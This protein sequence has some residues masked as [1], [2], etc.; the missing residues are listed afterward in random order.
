MTPLALLALISAL[1]V[2][3]LWAWRERARHNARLLAAEADA[4]RL[5]RLERA[6]AEAANLLLALST[7]IDLAR[8][9]PEDER[10]RWLA[11]A[12][13]ASQALVGLF[14][15]ARA[16]VAGAEAPERWPLEG[17]LRLAVALA[18]AEGAGI[19]LLGR[20]GGHRLA[21]DV[22]AA[23]DALQRALLALH[24]RRDGGAYVA[25]TLEAE[26]VTLSV[27]GE[28]ALD[29]RALGEALAPAGWRASA[30]R[31]G[32]VFQVSLRPVH[33]DREDRDPEAL[34][35]AAPGLA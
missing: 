5:R 34:P 24:A 30:A 20:G 23:V 2:A 29:L 16:L 14:E 13:E 22:E 6:G 3:L 18:R 17:A 4:R 35:R 19:E 7:S 1:V 15:A 33:P 8:T 28:P 10:E 9:S 31:R 11:N 12:E 21:G 25:A 27:A 32:E 26:G